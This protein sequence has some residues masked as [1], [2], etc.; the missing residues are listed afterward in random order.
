MCR[1][2]GECDGEDE[3]EEVRGRWAGV[4]GGV[5]MWNGISAENGKNGENGTDGVICGVGSGGCVLF[6]FRGTRFAAR[7]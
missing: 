4:G 6:P 7:L 2:D 1:G 3:E 5:Q